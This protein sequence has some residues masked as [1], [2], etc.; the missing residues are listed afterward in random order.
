[1]REYLLFRYLLFTS[2]VILILVNSQN[3]VSC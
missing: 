3:G 2:L 1:M